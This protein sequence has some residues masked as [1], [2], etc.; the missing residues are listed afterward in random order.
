MNEQQ[1]RQAIFITVLAIIL[2]VVIALAIY[3]FK[4]SQDKANTDITK[5]PMADDPLYKKAKEEMVKK[6]YSFDKKAEMNREWTAEDLQ[7]MG[8]AFAER[9]GSYSS[10]SN[11]ANLLDLKLFMSPEMAKWA[12]AYVLKLQA[13]RNKDSVY[14]GISSLAVSGEVTQFDSAKGTAKAI[15]STQRKEIKGTNTTN[16]NQKLSLEFLKIN[17]EWKVDSASWLK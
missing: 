10:D 1:K 13:D 12:D 17:G 15:I 14:Y 8:M 7:K 2:I 9:L 11:Y 6:D 5:A 16:Y 3:F 4:K